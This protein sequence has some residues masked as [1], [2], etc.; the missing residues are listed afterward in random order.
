[1]VRCVVRGGGRP[2]SDWGE[3][4]KFHSQESGVRIAS[5]WTAE[6]MADWV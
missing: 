2:R 3:R 6:N 4:M 1:L 5:E